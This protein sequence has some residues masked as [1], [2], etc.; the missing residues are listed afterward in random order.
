MTRFTPSL[1]ALLALAPA[2]A[3]CASTGG[4]FGASDAHKKPAVASNAK[5]DPAK[6]GETANLPTDIESGVRQAREKRLAGQYDDAIH[7]LSQLMLVASDDHRV[8]G[9]YG[10]T[11]AENGRAP[12][13]VQFLTRAVALQPAEWSYY[14]ALGVAYD[15]VGNQDAARMAYEQ[16]LKLRPGD[17]AILNNYALSRML[18][19]DP[20]G[21]R[22]LMARA[23]KAGGASDPKIARNI[24]LVNKVAPPALKTAADTAPAEHAPAALPKPVSSESLPAPSS[25]N[26][27]VSAKS[28]VVM[29]PVPS[30]PMAGPSKPAKHLVSGPASH[31]AKTA[32]PIVKQ[33][34][35]GEEKPM[36]AAKADVARLDTKTA[37]G[38]A[39][40][41]KPEIP[42]LRTAK[43][44]SKDVK[45][46]EAKPD[47]KTPAKP[48]TKNGIP[49]LRQT[50]SAY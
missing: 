34:H 45:A 32:A 40:T 3:G 30:D 36:T 21:A 1:I 6:A 13:A 47:T 37:K 50:A 29:Q 43:P 7:I 12:E 14:S 27:S 38:D 8:V 42:S 4:L 44:D 2:L 48:A 20:G 41:D 31:V 11:L 39:K 15:Q 25:Q 35:N 5:D 19:N 23:E 24:E 18:A 28:E 26:A 22:A 9:E 33:A 17:A 49:A 46:A 10:K 16:A